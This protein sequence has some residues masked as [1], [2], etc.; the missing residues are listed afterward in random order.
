MPRKCT[1]PVREPFPGTDSF[2]ADDLPKEVTD[3]QET[4]YCLQSFLFEFCI[5]PLHDETQPGFLAGLQNMIL[6]HGIHSNIAKACQAV[7]FASGGICLGRP[8][9]TKKAE[10][11]Y[12]DLLGELA[13]AVAGVAIPAE[14][15][16][17]AIAMLLGLYEVRNSSGSSLTVLS[18]LF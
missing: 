5:A 18:K 4:I 12:N 16:L 1:L 15:E 3:E 6:Y 2:P 8:V 11:L 14:A 9:L 13:N 7:A 17:L 10:T